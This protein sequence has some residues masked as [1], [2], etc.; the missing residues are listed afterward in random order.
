M[1]LSIAAA[2]H[3]GIGQMGKDQKAKLCDLKASRQLELYSCA[4]QPSGWCE[5]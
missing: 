4:A 3:V 2:M 5:G 1:N